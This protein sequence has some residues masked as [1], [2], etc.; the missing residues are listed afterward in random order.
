MQI[1]IKTLTGKTITLDVEPSDTIDNVKAKI[2]DKEGIPPD[3]QRLIFAGKQLEDGRTLSDYNIQKEAT[4][5]LVLRLRGGAKQHRKVLRDNI[6]GVTAPAIRRL[7]HTAGVKK[8]SGLIYEEIR[9]VLKIYLEKVIKDAVTY[10]EHARRKTVTVADVAAA[11]AHQGRPILVGNPSLATKP[12]KIKRTK[13]SGGAGKSRP[14]TGA[15]QNIRYYQ[16]QSHCLHIPFTPFERLVR[17]ISQYFKAGLRF[18]KD[19]IL[20]LQHSTESYLVNLFQDTN[21]AAIHAKRTGIMPK[22]IQLARRIRG[23]RR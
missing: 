15:L 4:L 21:I 18:Q 2:Q 5:H 12:C 22:D 19:A 3:Q 13:G 9:G 20:L 8:I 14:G 10:T 16:K 17:E 1:F 7:A 6:Q 23:E 11:L